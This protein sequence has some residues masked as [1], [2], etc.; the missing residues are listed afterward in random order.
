[1]IAFFRGWLIFFP[2]LALLLVRVVLHYLAQLV[3]RLPDRWLPFAADV[4]RAGV[5]VGRVLD[6]MF[7]WAGV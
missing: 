6:R 2:A 4:S 1:M 7:S 5:S 3:F